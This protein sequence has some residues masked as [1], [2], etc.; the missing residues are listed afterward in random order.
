MKIFSAGILVI[1]DEILSGRT[2]DTNSN[3]I[4][5]NL[6]Q[7]GIQLNEIKVIHDLEE[8]IIKCVSE[9]SKKYTYVFTTG[10]IGPTHDDITSESI[11]KAFNRKYEYHSEAYNILE[12]YYSNSDFSESRKKMA[13][14]P[15]NVEL[16]PN[17]ITFAPGFKI[18]NVFVLPGIPE[19]MEKMFLQVLKKIK[20]GPPKNIITIKTDLYESVIAISLSEIQIKFKDCSIGSYPFF[21][22]ATKKAGVNIVISSWTKTKLDDIVLEIQNRIKFKGGKSSIV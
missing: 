15:S 10:G 8:E 7:S 2:H 20:K 6:I 13:K 11:S 18:E 19:I 17:P 16:I 3:F 4:A 1:G 5:K 9:F 22:F 14:M 21:N 12:K